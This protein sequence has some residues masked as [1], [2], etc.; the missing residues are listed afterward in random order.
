MKIQLF[1]F[2]DLFGLI[3]F[4]VFG[5]LTWRNFFSSSIFVFFFTCMS[6]EGWL[7]G[8]FL[9]WKLVL[10]GFNYYN[11]KHSYGLCVFST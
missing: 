8:Y 5:K 1:F 2:Q 11:A 9:G 7:T 4:D 10:N 6:Y 3:D